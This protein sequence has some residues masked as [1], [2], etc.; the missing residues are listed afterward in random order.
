M[1][2]ALER[3]LRHVDHHDED[4]SCWEWLS[5]K[6]RKGYGR[7]GF[8]GASNTGF[9]HRFALEMKLGRPISP[10]LFACH[11]CD[12]PGCVKAEHLYEG[13][14][15]QNS[16]DM[17]ARGR[18]H[19][20]PYDGHCSKGHPYVNF[21]AGRNRCAECPAAAMARYRAKRVKT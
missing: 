13:T 17:V 5:S 21:F 9:A 15:K 3:F 1:S 6:D 7:F 2:S 20:M 16:G 10:S 4:D 19:G 14:A 8:G 18:V 11:H 12:N